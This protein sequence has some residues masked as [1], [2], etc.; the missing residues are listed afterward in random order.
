MADSIT[1][2]AEQLK[3]LFIEIGAEWPLFPEM[4]SARQDI[5]GLSQTSPAK[6]LLAATADAAADLAAI[7]LTTYTLYR[8][9]RQT[10]E[11]RGYERPWF[12]KRTKLSAA[13]LRLF[14]GD[15]TLLDVVQDY[16]W[17][18]CE[19]TTWVLPAHEW[20]K[21]DLFS[22]ETGFMFAQMLAALSDKLNEEIQDR[23]RA[24]LER[25][26]LTPY[27]QYH[28]EFGWYKGHS[29]WNGVCNGSVGSTFILMEKNEQRLAD[30]ISAVLSG[31]DIF[32]H[33]AFED[34]GASTEGS[35][36]WGY[37]LIHYVDFA[38]LL[39]QR[40]AG[41]IDIL[42]GERMK[43]IA[44]Y[45]PRV[46]LS[47]GHYAN[48]SDCHETVY[49]SPGMIS[50]MAERTG[51]AE[52]RQVLSEPILSA[53]DEDGLDLRRSLRSWHFAAHL[54]NLLWWDGAWGKAPRIQDS[55]LAKAGVVRLA[56]QTA[57]GATVVAAIKGGHNAENHNQNDVGSVIV[58]AGGETFLCDPGTG[59]YSRQYFSNTRYDNIFANS[60][61]HSLP[62]VGGRLQS[63]GREFEGHVLNYAP[64]V[65]PKKAVVEIGKA[66]AVP[67]L[68]IRR[69]LT[70]AEGGEVA[71]QDT[72][73]FAGE[74]QEV[75]EALVTW[76]DAQLSGETAILKGQ[77]RSLRLTIESPI[78]ATFALKELSEESQANAKE[79][80]L[81]R[82]TIKLPAAKLSQTRVRMTWQN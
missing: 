14:L 16:I 47:P 46:M 51:V 79:G 18:L 77:K 13:A 27:L 76:L 74:A 69:E 48:F 70:L 35:G 62:V 8:Q 23:M 29:N 42:A 82:L 40:T 41:R 36:Y 12:E 15:D 32:I 9:F 78:G 58:H 43:A 72:F 61:G 4:D 31:L 20:V 39:R 65:A 1:V 25:R 52:L 17:N 63:A 68:S 55:Y 6:Q 24:E 71:L 64:E 45:P 21:I 3:R 28:D 10:G 33:T 67:G 44:A 22:A 38:E 75:E 2:P 81:K 30:A 56:A 50:R 80:I 34:D 7:P 57:D 49:F 5:A 11:R 59:L 60:F 53:T 66:Y 54:R 73:A 19:E 37:G 26:I